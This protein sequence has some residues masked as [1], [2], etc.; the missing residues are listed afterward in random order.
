LSI[1]YYIVTQQHGGSIAVDS[2][3]GEYSEFM[4]RLPRGR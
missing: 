1:T 2:E 4:I 3:V